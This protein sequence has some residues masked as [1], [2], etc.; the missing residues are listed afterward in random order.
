MVYHRRFCAYN[1]T[2]R[3]I[4]DAATE[5][6]NGL[7]RRGVNPRGSFQMRVLRRRL[8]RRGVRHV[9]LRGLPYLEDLFRDPFFL[10]QFE[11]GQGPLR[12]RFLVQDPEPIQQL[13]LAPVQ[14]DGPY[15][16]EREDDQVPMIEAEMGLPQL[17]ID[18]LKDSLGM[19]RGVQFLNW[20]V[21]G[22]WHPDLSLFLPEHQR[23]PETI[24]LF[25]NMFY[26]TDSLVAYIRNWPVFN[27]QIALEILEGHELLFLKV[28]CSLDS[29]RTLQHARQILFERDA[30]NWRVPAFYF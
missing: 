22:R 16:E 7:Y 5:R 4:G 3:K 25:E 26:S 13:P 27:R 20:T 24:E 14:L 28:L 30:Y 1:I 9:P 21:R 23:D 6:C 18:I 10:R 17:T 8:G 11:G 15:E 19:S 12:Q 29:Q 2:M